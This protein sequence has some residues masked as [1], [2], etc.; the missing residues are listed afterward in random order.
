MG[1]VLS[2]DWE[3]NIQFVLFPRRNIYSVKIMLSQFSG[4]PNYFPFVDYKVS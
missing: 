2:L 1:I 3:K 4:N